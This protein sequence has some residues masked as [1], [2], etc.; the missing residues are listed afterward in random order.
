MEKKTSLSALLSLKL[1]QILFPGSREFWETR[2]SLGGNSGQGSY[3]KFAEFKAEVL[4]DFVREK[5][6]PSVIEFGC[7][8]GNQLSLS[9]YPKYIGLDVSSTAISLCRERFGQ[10]RSKSFFLYSPSCFVD[11]HNV[12]QA[13]LGL[14]L[15]VIYH[16]VEDD[17]YHAYMDHIFSASKRFAIIYSSD[18]NQAGGV[19]AR[20]VRHRNFSQSVKERFPAW[21]LM[22]K[23]KNPYPGKG[24]FG[25]GSFADFFI[26]EKAEPS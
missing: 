7:G 5:A 3:G 26:F 14:S 25:Q 23:I 24:D 10:D 19:H 1:K 4:N 22:E 20:H 2:Y 11:H 17:I 9:E 6:I 12:F 18:M 21:K 15:D 13:D 16:L 8:D